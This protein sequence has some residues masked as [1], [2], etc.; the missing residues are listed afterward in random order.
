MDAQM[1]QYAASEKIGGDGAFLEKLAE[2]LGQYTTAG[3]GP[4]DAEV[5]GVLR[6]VLTHLEV[7]QPVWR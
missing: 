5:D 1:G 6:A 3:P 2:K 4:D 7:E